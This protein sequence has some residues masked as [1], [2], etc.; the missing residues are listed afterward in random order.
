M[1]LVLG[2]WVTLLGVGA[3]A[4]SE[5]SPE[6]SV[7]LFHYGSNLRPLLEES[8]GI[9]T[10][11]IYGAGNRII[12]QVI[13]NSDGDERVRYLLADHLGSTRLG[14]DQTGAVD[15]S[16]G[17]TPYGETTIGGESG[18][19]VRYRYTG[20]SEDS[21]LGSYHNPRRSYDPGLGRFLSVDPM[22][23][24]SSPYVYAGHD[25]MNL[26]DPTGGQTFHFVLIDYA[27]FPEIS[28]SV[29]KRAVRRDLGLGPERSIPMWDIRRLHQVRREAQDPFVAENRDRRRI[30]TT[31]L[32]YHSSQIR[33]LEADVEFKVTFVIGP[34]SKLPA[35]KM[36]RTMFRPDLGHGDP[37]LFASNY[38]LAYSPAGDVQRG[39]Q[40]KLSGFKRVRED[41]DRPTSFHMEQR[42]FSDLVDFRASEAAR[43]EY[44]SQ[45]GADIS[46]FSGHS[47]R[48]VSFDVT[49]QIIE[50]GQ[51]PAGDS[52]RG[53]TDIPRRGILK[54]ASPLADHTP[55]VLPEP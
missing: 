32:E 46:Q 42:E 50:S 19:E 15:A 37:D 5:E 27:G 6:T 43:L 11:N 25:P 16:F 47:P 10:L 54:P 14:L 2:V 13:R 39:Y 3:T 30:G 24:D 12:A 49:P 52:V 35:D 1:A 28:K 23:Q 45:Q 48:H 8:G 40:R 22:R 4:R 18:G 44:A 34:D 9:Q 51:R 20:H 53:L 36:L 7:A 26:V 17:Y 29:L 41:M 31:H 38:L 21:A 55:L 33:E